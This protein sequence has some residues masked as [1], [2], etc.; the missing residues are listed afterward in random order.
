MEQSKLI[1][2]ITSPHQL[3]RL[4]PAELTQLAAELRERIVEVV[5]RRGGHLASNLGVAELTIALHY[6]FDFSHDRLV[7]DVGHQCY[8]HKI[9]TGRGEQFDS[10]RRRAGLSGFPSPAESPYDLFYTGHAG[11]A[12][13]TAAG[14]AQA[15]Q[16]MGANSRVVA[17]VGDA[18]IVNGVAL[19]GLNNAALLRRQFLIVLNDNSMAIDRTR[20]ALAHVLDHIRASQTYKDIKASTEH[21]LQHLPL[22][23]EI[24][25][26]LRNIKAGLKTT[27]HGGQVFES[28]GFEYYGPV[29]GHDIPELIRELRRLAGLQYPALLHVHTQKGHGCRYAVEDPC[30]FHSPSA[31]T[32][33]AGKVVFE[34]KARATWTEAFAE[35]LID[36]ARRDDRVVA[37][38][39]AMPDGTGLA[40]FREVFPDRCTD[41]GINES[42]A[43]AMAAG[44]AK[45]GMRPVVAI[46]STFLQRAFDQVFHEIALQGLPVMLC[47]DRAG[48]VGP[49]GA[50]HHGFM[51]IAYLRPLPGMV[52]MAPADVAEMKAAME[53]GLSLDGP[54]AIRYPRDEVP[55]ELP[56][57][58]PPFEVGRARTLRD[59]SD[60]ALLCYGAMVEPALRAAE[61]LRRE[62]QMNVAVVSARFAKPLDVTCL[63]R[64]IR[65]G[66]PVLVCE[67]HAMLGGFG[68]AVLELAAARGLNAQN[69]R[70]LGIPDRFIAHASRR[71]QLTE[72]G[73]DATHFA[74]AM[75]DLIRR[76][77]DSAAQRSR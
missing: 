54:S 29:D 2:R 47:I 38:T 71:E 14:L 6:V 9:L 30:R 44:L 16:A 40:R 1:H 34:R 36:L 10:L 31:H 45:A 50:V 61:I 23:E 22:G 33:R 18:S 39:A 42:H 48:L 28:L 35:S 69:V 49:D 21:V 75:K 27:I 43:V 26:A 17:V 60:G 3:R 67:D 59:G 65:A 55:D 11:T 58:C 4:S 62:E 8:P 73:L 77:A 52:L 68:S 74:A 57:E 7:W 19:E 76:R 12:I 70:I 72:V 15:D 24:T 5:A 41:V 37:I 20:G 66:G 56:G 51:D 46:Y 63:S 32:V 25:D 13:S 53:L 64:R